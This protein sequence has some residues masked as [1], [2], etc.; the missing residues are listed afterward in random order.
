MSMRRIPLDEADLDNFIETALLV[1]RLLIF[2][3]VRKPQPA[4]DG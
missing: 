3:S 2:E 4:L 1:I